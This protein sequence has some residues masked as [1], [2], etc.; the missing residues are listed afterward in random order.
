M[1]LFIVSV[2]ILTDY[3]AEKFEKDE[4][5][6]QVA[7]EGELSNCKFSQGHL[8]FTL[9]DEKAE[10]KGV[11]YKG[12]ASA[13]PF[14][15]QDGQKVVVF[16]RVAV[17]KRRGLYQ[18]YAE[19]IEPL[20]LGALYLK[21]EQTK[22]KL[23]EKGYFDEGRKK[24]LPRY[25]EKIGIITSKTG[26][27]IRDILTTIKKRWPK[28]TLYLVPV[29]VQGEEAPGQIIKAI[30]LLNRLNLCEIIILARGGGS[31]EELS[32]FNEET[33]ADAIYA[34]NIPI[35]T[36]IGHETDFSIADMVA[37]R[38]AP[39]PTG[40]AVEATPNLLEIWGTLE[41][42]RI[43]MLKALSNY[44]KQEQKNLEH[45]EKRLMRAFEK[46]I[47]DKS[48]EVAE[49][50]TRL[51]KSFQTFFWQE[52]N[53]LSF[54]REKLF[55]LSP[56]IRYRQQQEKLCELKGR[57]ILKSQEILKSSQKDLEQYNLRLKAALKNA[58]SHYNLVI[59]S[60]EEKLKLLN[61]LNVL[62]RGYAAIFTL[63]GKVITSIKGLPEL[64]KVKF[65]DGEALAKTLDKNIIKGDENDDL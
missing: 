62:N 42:H 32:A 13:L 14:V 21:F 26:A 52:K 3:I 8:Y 20:G 11:M 9:K 30:N 7:V 6:N 35:V 1:G 33:V 16:G 2:S 47:T 31:F 46:L 5:L 38:R 53:R 29:T 4:F 18:L 17:F 44:L 36:G 60:Y 51:L 43:N 34:S 56:K 15:P 50:F 12:R 57:L 54:L 22:E 59:S 40:A 27:A 65:S 41:K 61:P 58:A 39:T 28:A 10:L 63:D 64:F 45:N 48:R 55:L 19:H 24:S 25:P 37:D 49:S 23:K